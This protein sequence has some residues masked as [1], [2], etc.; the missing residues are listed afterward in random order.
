MNVAPNAIQS[1]CN[2]YFRRFFF[3]YTKHN[4]VD[5]DDDV[6]T[7][8]QYSMLSRVSVKM[9]MDQCAMWNKT[10]KLRYSKH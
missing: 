10:H 6:N 8:V 9:T 5:N 3:D 2:I 1:T 7:D 4:S